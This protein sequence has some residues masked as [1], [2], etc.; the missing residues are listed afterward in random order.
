MSTSINSDMDGEIGD[1]KT[2]E[3]PSKLSQPR[4]PNENDSI[5]YALPKVFY[6]TLINCIIIHKKLLN[7]Y[8]Q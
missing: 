7:N 1:L 2:E 4:V 6:L 5:V 8:F 3:D